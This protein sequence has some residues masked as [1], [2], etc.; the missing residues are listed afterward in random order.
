MKRLPL[1]LHHGLQTSPSAH[2]E[3]QSDR[4]SEPPQD[5]ENPGCR[6]RR[7]RRRSSQIKGKKKKPGACSF[8]PHQT[9]A[10]SVA[11]PPEARSFYH[12]RSLGRAHSV[13]PD[14]KDAIKYSRVAES[15]Y[16]IQ[17]NIYIYTE[18]ESSNQVLSSALLIRGKGE[19]IWNGWCSTRTY[20]RDGRGVHIL[21][22]SY[23]FVQYEAMDF[24]TSGHRE[25]H[26]FITE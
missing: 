21:I 3:A 23:R 18:R 22:V 8:I 7:W 19:Y 4:F 6:R 16:E 12:R 14:F 25:M 17:Q 1:P 15:V 5:S 20:G 10:R 11:P 9:S 24:R 13:Q 2:E 26:L